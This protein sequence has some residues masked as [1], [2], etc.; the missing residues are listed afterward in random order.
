MRALALLLATTLPAAAWEVVPADICTVEH[1]GESAQVTLTYDHRS[2]EY[3]IEIERLNGAWPAAPAFSI[4][5]DGAGALVISTPRHTLS[6][7]GRTITARDTGF[8]NV[9]NGLE[10]NDTATAFTGQAAETLDL[11]GDKPAAP[12]IAAFRACTEP[13]IA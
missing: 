4:R 13:G 3:A 10:F 9:L 11:R 5:F 12:A 2:R 7:D 6:P 1:V 8:G